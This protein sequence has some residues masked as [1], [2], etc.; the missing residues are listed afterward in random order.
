MIRP[1]ASLSLRSFRYRKYSTKLPQVVG[2]N[3]KLLPLLK[4]G[5]PS[6]VTVYIKGFLARGEK[7]EDFSRWRESHLKLCEST[8]HGWEPHA[9]GYSWQNESFKS[10]FDHVFGILPGQGSTEISP[11]RLPITIPVPII[12]L[13]AG[14]AAILYRMIRGAKLLTPLGFAIAASQDIALIAAQL[15]RQYYQA[16]TNA[17]KHA[18]VLTQHLQELKEQNPDLFIRVVAHSLGS[19]LALK[20][21]DQTENVINE[22]HLLA[23]AVTHTELEEVMSHHDGLLPVDNTFIYHSTNDYILE[24]FG[25]LEGDNAI[26]YHGPKKQYPGIEE[27]NVTQYLEGINKH[28]SYSR[29]FHNFAKIK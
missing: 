26:G 20:S 29:V 3:D 1:F 22:L 28:K 24:I 10:H 19:K 17:V 12:T 8:M 11:Y 23:P 27:V 6:E 13:G 21:I 18:P 15:S 5:S 9:L 2:T 14:A 4:I 25:L 7:P 16:R